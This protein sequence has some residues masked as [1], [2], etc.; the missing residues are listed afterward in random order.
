MKV[1][2]TLLWL[3]LR[4][5]WAWA[6]GLLALLLLIAWI[7]YQVNHTQF[8]QTSGT[9]LPVALLINLTVLIMSA[10]FAWLMP[11][12]LATGMLSESRRGQ[13]ELLL[14]SPA[15]G[16]LHVLARFTFAF[17]VLLLF[18]SGLLGIAY[19]EVLRAGVAM[20]PS[21][22]LE[23]YGYA[24]GGAPALALAVFLGTLWTAY[25]PSGGGLLAVVLGSAGLLSLWSTLT[26]Y[27]EPLLFRLSPWRIPPIRMNGVDVVTATGLPGLP[28][29]FF[30]LMLVLTILLLY[31]AGR[32]WGEVEV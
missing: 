5:L 14:S 28:Q 19:A 24:L 16:M 1:F 12:L 23:L 13:L 30:W 18:A 25:Q 22:G 7:V 17:L 26:A 21:I 20:S 3:E 31:L 2:L 9:D 10:Q 27:L 15:P 4:K 6:L 11:L 29:E 32:I 8:N